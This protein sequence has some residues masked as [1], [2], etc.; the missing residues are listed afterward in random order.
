MHINNAIQ[1]G[2]TFLEQQQLPHGEFRTLIGP[3]KVSAGEEYVWMNS[4]PLLEDS[5]P[6]VSTF[7][8]HTLGQINDPR[9][10]KMLGKCLTFLKQEM[11]PGGLW[12]YYSSRQFKHFRI[13]PDLDSSACVSHCLS[14][15]GFD[16]PDN[17]WVF[18]HNR[19]RQGR[20]LT[21]IFPR[22]VSFT[23][24]RLSLLRFMH[25]RLIRPRIP[26]I[27]VEERKNPRFTPPIDPVPPAD[28]DP[29]VNA[30]VLLYMGENSST[31]AAVDYILDII[32][33]GRE[34]ETNLY[35]TDDLVLYYLIARAYRNGSES[36]ADAGELIVQRTRERQRGDGSL[37]GSA[38][39]TALGIGALLSFDPD[40]DV[41]H[42]AISYLIKNQ[43]KD[44]SWPAYG[45]YAGPDECWGSAELTTAICM[46]VLV[47]WQARY[48][49]IKDIVPPLNTVWIN[50]NFN[51]FSPE[52]CR[53]PFS[54][55]AALRE[56]C[57]VFYS[58]K[59]NL[60]I[61]SRYNDVANVLKNSNDYSSSPFAE[62]EPLL[63]GADPPEHTR[64]RRLLTPAFS[65]ARIRKLDDKIRKLAHIV[66]DSISDKGQCDLVAE[67]TSRLPVYV[68]IELLGLTF[69]YFDKLKQWSN[70]AIAQPDTIKDPG[71]RNNAQ[72][73]VRDFNDFCLKYVQDYRNRKINQLILPQID[74]VTEDSEQLTDKE[75][76][77]L[78]RLLIIAAFETTRNLLGNM[79]YTLLTRPDL[80]NEVRN[81]PD[82]HSAFIEESLRIDSPTQNL[83]RRTTNNTVI[84]EQTIPAG[85]L[86][87]VLLGSAN[88]DPQH[89][90]NP[91][92]FRLDR[93]KRGHLAFGI[94][95]HTCLGLHLARLEARITLEEV[96]PRLNNL[97]L[98]DPDAPYAHMDIPEFRA[99]Q[100]LHVI[101]DPVSPT[102]SQE[103]G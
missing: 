50:D 17:H 62:V 14:T 90:T 51:I 47:A 54:Y 80:M 59:N 64:V 1:K 28:I 6:F 93:E 9:C 45:F 30:N 8:A 52:V 83:K 20:F 32:R 78:V 25:D 21:W 29:A 96:L 75:I 38:F 5:S 18:K 42:D 63:L 31:A 99:P 35:Y 67:F 43:D 66:T 10:R 82:C 13:P 102:S 58:Q 41:M 84:G 91:E 2:I 4:A 3:G 74:N 77:E 65:G 95:P 76:A 81:N 73:N 26:K 87:V 55:Y 89:Y 103:N 48:G 40:P 79:F 88:H 37:S 56:Q 16:F 24:L 85:E 98:Y 7:V 33:N 69:D 71:A 72:Q 44:G 36:L 70:A 60:W 86:V 53:D 19:D 57:P 22:S 46:E 39:L 68:V 94:G 34:K 23:G 92:Q 101:F 49:D 12:R 100:H 15:H 11:E 27:P 97:R 61:I